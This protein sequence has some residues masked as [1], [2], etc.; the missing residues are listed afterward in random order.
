M[1]KS[2]LYHGFGITG[3]GYQYKSTEFKNGKIIFSI[4][5]DPSSLHCPICNSRDVVR[6]GTVER[7]FKALPIGKKPVVLRFGAQRVFCRNCDAVRQVEI[8]FAEEYRTY[9]NQFERYV[10]ELLQ[11]MTVSSVANHLNVSWDFV[12]DI[13]KRDLEKEFQKPKL[14]E[15]ILIA[16]DEIFIGKKQGYLTVV[17]DLNTGA[18]VFVGDGKSSASLDPFWKSLKASRAEVKA[19]ATDMGA[20][21]IK[22]VKEN[23]P[24]AILVFDHFH[25]V[26]LFN[27]KLENLRREIQREADEE[28]AEVL[29]GTRWLLLKKSSNLDDEKNERQRL[30]DALELNAPLAVGYYLGEE[31][32]DIWTQSN[33]QAAEIEFEE[34]ATTAEISEIDILC[35]F[36]KTMRKHKNEILAYYDY[37]ISTG[38]LEGTNNKIKTLKRQAYGFRDREYFKLKLKALHRTKYSLVG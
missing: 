25:V 13:D 1:S 29:K 36:A 27:E 18:I 33:K 15:L 37:R 17:M 8:S 26:K 31:L 2:L 23:L 24:T 10:L 3:R 16:I 22:A 11:H 9:T 35:G 5:Q 7:Q 20:A 4:T 6:R 19:V 12:K 34:W 14:K 21:Y 30:E 28:Q 38:P 32:N